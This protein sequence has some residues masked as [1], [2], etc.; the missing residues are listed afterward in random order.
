MKKL[1]IIL[2]SVSLLG[3]PSLGQIDSS[4]VVLNQIPQNYFNQIDKKVE[5]YDRQIT[6][7]TER[8]LSKLV[9][10]ESK[11][12]KTL[13]KIDPA[14]SKRLF[15]K[16]ERTFKYILQKINDGKT[17]KDNYKG[18]YSEYRDKISVNLNYLDSKK[19]SLKTEFVEPIVKAKNKFQKLDSNVRN[20]EA[21]E[22]MIKQRKKE[23]T[24]T[25]L[26]SGIKS[27][28]VSKINKEA[29][30]YSES[31]RNYKN[32]FS[33]PKKS[34]EVARKL[35][36]K[37][38]AFKKFS[39]ENSE[40][41]SLFGFKGNSLN[42]EE[43][44]RTPG[45]QTRDEINSFINEKV[46][47]GGPKAKEYISQ[48]IQKAAGELK[49]MQTK[50]IKQG[51]SASGELPDFKPN[52]QRSK[53]FAQRI[54]YSFN[55]QFNRSNAL[56]PTTTELSFGVG[57]KLNDRSIFGFGASY[58]LGLGS[59]EHIKFSHEGLGFLSYLDWKLKNQFYASGGFEMKY[60]ANQNLKLFNAQGWQPAGLVGLSKKIP[61]KSKRYKSL[62][63][64]LLYDIL[65]EQKY[66]RTQSLVF[67]S[68]FNF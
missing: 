6:N 61:V 26:N 23:L 31:L 58:K 64:Q 47:S 36:D 17:V 66:P 44:L 8:S 18:S 38:P 60:C 53:T 50:L 65:R 49:K 62:K 29:Y 27:K 11:I 52:S 22:E 10:W 21:I 51:N 1:L 40:Y 48:N 59:L 45:I 42:L 63:V 57:Y 30:Y 43:I 41:A 4:L 7:R 5:K 54:E 35:L 16:K 33:D 25:I 24:S 68:G 37:L 14:T 56:I 2:I 12:K 67:R 15:A 46:S 39:S 20:S 3:K 13:D 19:D 32:I 34:E 28:Y 9:K 55:T